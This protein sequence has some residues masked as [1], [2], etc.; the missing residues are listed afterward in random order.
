MA[1]FKK[2]AYG[3]SVAAL[4]AL[5]PVAAVHAQTTSANLRG[6][7]V[8]ASGAPVSGATVTII[9]SPSGTA[10]RAVTNETG[11]FFQSGLRVGGP[12]SIIVAA[13]GFQGEALDGVNLR[14]GNQSPLTLTLNPQAADVIVVTG[15]AINTTDLNNGVGSNFSADDIANQPSANRDV[16]G[17]LVRDPLAFSDGEGQLYVAGVNPRFNGLAIDGS[18]QQDDFG[19]GSN[20]YAT[21]RSPISLDA[22]ESASL[23]ASDYSVTASGFT[24]GLVNITTK[25]GT[26]E[27]DGALYYY[28]QDEEYF[29]DRIDGQDVNIA[30]FDEKEYGITL[31]GPIIEDR[32]FFFVSYDEFESGSGTDYSVG[33]S[34]DGIDTNFYGALNQYV[35]DNLGYDMG[36]R[37]TVT[38]N[39]VTS[40]RLIGKIDWNINDNHRA[41]FTYQSTEE[42]GTSTGRQN[43]ESAWYDIPVELTSYSGSVFSDWSDN[44]STTVRATYK[45]FSRGQLCRA[46]SDTAHL[47]F[48]LTPDDL[49]GSPLEGLLIDN[50]EETFVGGCDRFRH[51]NEFNDERLQLFAQGDYILGDHLITFG[52]EYEDYSLFNLFVAGSNGRFIYRSLDEIANNTPQIDYVNANTNNADDAAA[53]FGLEKITLFA[54][55]TWQVR[56][57]LEVGFGVR[58]ETYQQDDVPPLSAD[59]DALYGANTTGQNLDGLDLIMPRASFRWE[60]NDRTT[61]TGGFGLFAGG[62]PK[63]WIS[64]AFQGATGFARQSSGTPT[65]GLTVP[66]PLLDSVAGSTGSVIDVVADDFEIPS[67]WKASLRVDYDLNLEALGLG[68]GYLLS[69]SWLYTTPQDAFIWRNRAQTDLAAALPTGV[70][71]DGRTIYAD[72]DDLGFANLTELG[73]A[74]GSESHVFSVAVQKDYENG[75]GFYTS[76][77]YQDVDWVSEGG[78]SRGISNWRGLSAIDR[79]NPEVRTSFWEIE[80]SFKIGL[81]YEREIIS[82]LTSRVDVFGQIRSGTP[83]FLTYDVSGSNS[84]F[85]RAGAG[86]SPYDN[87]PIY[88]PTRTGD[89]NVVFATGFDT[90]GFYDLVNRAGAAEGEIMPVNS[91]SGAWNQQWDLRFTQEL[92]GIPGIDRFVGDNNF[93][94]VMDIVNFPN[95]LNSD[96][97]SQTNGPGFG[98]FTAVDADLVSATDVALNGVDGATALRGDDIRTTCTTA[99]SCV[100]RYND[101]RAAGRDINELD[102]NDSV[103]EIRIGLRYEF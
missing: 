40:E 90:A 62:E 92:P 20:T 9:H 1:M 13:P 98:Q 66:Q 45:E 42:S 7:I 72:L 6:E 75:F 71:P 33:D 8:D 83:Y 26:N 61:L 64:N 95:L 88:V 103:Y 63:V 100:Y 76:Y 97:G 89:A 34:N 17:T 99:A 101:F 23:V 41:S 50:G 81:S 82:D 55:D 19:L 53:A 21:E 27:F 24:G 44:F 48:R 38:S 79:N 84:L 29:G 16:I 3:A 25:S 31:G 22:V 59:V 94:F 85:G 51:A 78:S 74:D 35:L 70:A 37:P 18:L 11:Q 15:Q 56:D 5:A 47:E 46:G 52:A 80:H 58:Y 102:R 67:D 54:Q 10:S 93:E 32:L 77:A 36:G 73:N 69:A 28:Y 4:A 30:P 87:N 39:P 65:A 91:A 2:F 14:P 86:E 43:F 12:Y 68:D 60:P 49:V 57:N 96:W